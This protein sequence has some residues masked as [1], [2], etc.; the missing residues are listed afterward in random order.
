MDATISLVSIDLPEGCNVI[1]G[2]AHFIK[3][4][5][6]LYEAMAESAPGVKFGVAF[7]EASGKRLI[8]YEGNDKELMNSA[9]KEIQKIGAGHTFL[10][11]M[12]EGYPVNVLNAIKSV[13]E[14]CTVHAATSN[15]LQAVVV[16]SEQGRGI[17]GVIDGSAPLGVEGE[18]DINERYELLRKIG[19]KL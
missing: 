9:V 5:E 4:V 11:F 12:K 2:H 1:L 14:V 18:A 17:I 3:T 13:S 6:D 7:C 19:Y 15:P 16:E 8:R 10:I